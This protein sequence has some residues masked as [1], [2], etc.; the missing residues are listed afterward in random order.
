MTPAGSAAAPSAVTDVLAALAVDPS[1]PRF[2]GYTALGRTELSGTV[3]RNWAAKV[4]G[5]LVDELGAGPQDAVLIRTPA[6][7]Q[8][9]G[10]VL[11]ALWAGV[12][13]SD[14]PAVTC[15]AAFVGPDD[16]RRRRERRRGVRGLRPPAGR[17]GQRYPAGAA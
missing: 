12:A 14:D 8:T 17:P 1:R 6:N 11:G 4:A 3:L 10:L 9:A 7:W 15:C 16:D 5:L 13:I 2:T